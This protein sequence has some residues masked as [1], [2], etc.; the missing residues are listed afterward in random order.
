MPGITKGMLKAFKFNANHYGETML[1]KALITERWEKFF[2]DYDFLICPVAFGPSFK[3]CKL[4]SKL[5]YDGKDM[6]Y[7]KY[8]WPY[9]ACFNSSG[10]PSIAIPLG[11]GKEGLPIGV[12][13]VGK[14]W[15]EPELMHFAKKVGALT[16][17]FI[18]PNG[19]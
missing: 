10:N 4:G 3:R 15:S 14:Y 7:I 13:I 6:I 17:G 11:L 16:E 8:V 1:K 5:N 12:Q 19:Y 2:Y 18:K 9:T